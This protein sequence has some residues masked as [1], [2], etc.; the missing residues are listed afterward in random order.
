MQ[1]A[2]GTLDIR[3]GMSIS[4]SYP[5][6]KL[7][8]FSPVTLGGPFVTVG[9]FYHKMNRK[10]EHRVGACFQ[11]LSP[12]Y[13]RNGIDDRKLADDSRFRWQ[14]RYEAADYVL[15]DIG[16][17]G[18]DLGIGGH[19]LLGYAKTNRH[20]TSDTE[21]NFSEWTVH[22]AL[23]IRLQ[24]MIVDNLRFTLG[25]ANG[26]FYQISRSNTNRYGDTP[27]SWNGRGW[28]FSGRAAAYYLLGNQLSFYGAMVRLEKIVFADCDNKT[29]V[30]NRFELGLLY[31]L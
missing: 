17:H 1:S 26:G 7:E 30:E 21:K 22:A 3:S 29:L 20:F 5:L 28:H 13:L 19:F 8:N 11:F 12:L 10:S 24:Y 23:L 9:L 25:T 27:Y 14:L 2:F 15:R 6:E 16:I 4:G 31:R 18:L